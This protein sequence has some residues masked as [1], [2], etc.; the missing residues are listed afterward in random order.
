MGEN[1]MLAF[2]L[3]L[4]AGLSTGIGSLIAFFV[5][6]QSQKV[7]TVSMGFAAGVMLYVSFY[8]ILPEAIHGL[9]EALG[10]AHEGTYLGV[11]SFFMGI[12]L[13]MLIGRL[14]PEG[15]EAPEEL[16]NLSAEDMQTPANRKRLLRVGL[17]TA[18][19][20]AI[21]N[22]PEGVAVF[23]AALE[24]PQLGITIA[25]AIA[26]HNIPEGIA[27]SMPIY[28]A[29]GSRIKAF[30]YSFLSGLVEPIGAF[31]GY[32]FLSEYLTEA[33]M[34]GLLAAVAGMMVFISIDQ[35]LPTAS[36]F[37]DHK[38]SMYGCIAGMGVM[39][40][41]LLLMLGEHSH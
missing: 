29:T 12:F 1:V 31:L 41:S 19:A 22:F 30:M 24:N 28:F 21:H 40:L 17:L 9:T 23:T 20:L 18:L 36:K 25:I 15:D 3:T 6:E 8:E 35:L 39:A 27:V 7:L 16:I 38:L 37:G 32:M 13:V 14:I 2:G 26:I 33:V 11:G 4:I 34:G 5:K 10:C